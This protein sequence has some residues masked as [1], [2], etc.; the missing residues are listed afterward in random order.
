MRQS[1][2][3][4]PRKHALKVIDTRFWTVGPPFKLSRSG[5]SGTLN[6]EFLYPVLS[7]GVRMLV[8][9]KLEGTF[10]LRGSYTGKRLDHY[11]WTAL[12]GRK[13]PGIKGKGDW[14]EIWAKKHPVFSVSSWCYKRRRAHDRWDRRRIEK[15]I[16]KMLK[17]GWLERSDFCWHRS[18]RR[19]R[20]RR[21]RRIRQQSRR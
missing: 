4:Q 12:Y 9:M 8:R 3:G 1:A 19:K 18:Q 10:I 20:L 16:H 5:E 6:E 14:G 7:P 17:T 13:L 21:R 11:Q 15:Q 2:S